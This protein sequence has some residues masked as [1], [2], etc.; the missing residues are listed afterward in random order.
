MENKVE[1]KDELQQNVDT[2][3]MEVGNETPSS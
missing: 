3:L 2:N 1:Q